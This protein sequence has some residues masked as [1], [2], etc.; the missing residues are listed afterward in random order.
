[1]TTVV[2]R[3]NKGLIIVLK[4]SRNLEIR[5]TGVAVER[6]V[7]VVTLAYERFCCWLELEVILFID[8]MV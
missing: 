8:G 7:L 6:E 4:S 1:L 3:S 2:K 5:L